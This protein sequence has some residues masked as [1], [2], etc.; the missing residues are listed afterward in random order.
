MM[1]EMLIDADNA[2]TAADHCEA[3][4]RRFGVDPLSD[5]SIVVFFIENYYN[6]IHENRLY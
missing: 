2:T 6:R 1:P 5:P 4:L 3:G